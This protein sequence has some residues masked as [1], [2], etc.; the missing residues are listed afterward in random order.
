MKEEI[1][2]E[3]KFLKVLMTDDHWQWVKR[4]GCN[5]ACVIVPITTDNELVF[6]EQYRYP[7]HAQTI[8]F[9]AGLVADIDK[10]ETARLS[11]ERELLEE[12][13]YQAKVFSTGTSMYSSAGLTDEITTVFVA[14]GCKKVEEGGGDETE[15]I[16]VHVVPVKEVHQWID[17]MRKEGKAISSNV[18]YGL[19]FIGDYL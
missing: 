12:T 1:Q 14:Y 13:G 19:S 3:G 5:G 15:N 6:V 4:K 10:K 17:N 16:I 11:A 7:T 18:Y 9:P 2:F 8:E